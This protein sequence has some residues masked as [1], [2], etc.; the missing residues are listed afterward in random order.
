MNALP[1][2]ALLALAEPVSF[3]CPETLTVKPSAVTAPDGF[4]VFL[5]SNE[6]VYLEQVHFYRDHPSK[7]MQLKP[8]S[9]SSAVRNV[10]KWDVTGDKGQLFLVCR[11]ASTQ[12]SLAKPI[13]KNLRRCT[14]RSTRR[15][16]GV[17]DIKCLEASARKAQ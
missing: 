16:P 8:E 13:P 10:R 7:M 1:L 2:L 5:D 4:E 3:S 12:V 15:N 11:Y 14:V 6:A 17:F 9:R